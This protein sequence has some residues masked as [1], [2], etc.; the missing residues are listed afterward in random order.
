VYPYF[1]RQL[2]EN[3]NEGCS[4]DDMP[5]GEPSGIPSQSN[6]LIVDEKVL[7]CIREY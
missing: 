2:D 6:Y 3:P 7:K 5:L 1:L 4:K